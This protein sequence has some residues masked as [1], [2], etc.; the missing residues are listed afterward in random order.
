MIDILKQ[1]HP[2]RNILFFVFE[3]V[4]I[5]SS[6]LI[7]F[8]C[9]SQ[10]DGGS[11]DSFLFFRI[12]G[13][14]VI[15]QL[16][17]YYFDLYD[18]NVSN[19]VSEILI[20]LLMALGSAAIFLGLIYWFFPM[21]IVAT[22]VF[23]L[24]IV[25]LILLIL[26][27]RLLYILVLK[28][29][30]FNESI[31][32]LGSSPLALNILNH[33][34]KN[35]DC[36]YTVTAVI[37]DETH[38]IF[39]QYVANRFYFLAQK[40]KLCNVVAQFGV[41]KIVVALKDKRR[42]F[43]TEELLL[44]KVSGI[45]VLEGNTF[46]EALTGKLMVCEINPSWL[47]FSRGFYHSRLTAYSKRLGDLVISSLLLVLLFPVGVL[48]A[49]L[50]KLDS[51]GPVL[52][53]QERVGKYKKVYIMY[54]FR[55][56]INDAE[57]NTGPVWAQENDSRITRMGRFMRWCRLDELPQLWNV[58]IGNMSLVGPRPERQYFVD[59][60]EKEIPYYM[61][62][63]EVKP[64]ITGWAQILYDYGASMEDTMEKLGYDLFYIKNLSCLIDMVILMRTI[65]TVL[66]GRGAR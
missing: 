23:T 13:I 61:A 43:P 17:L 2:V 48:T 35:I 1:Y 10:N 41:R 11:L 4:I 18:L 20:R 46:Y 55:S 63:F 16:A 39:D 12:S 34:D 38:E 45:E 19:S 40:S 28:K 42:Q 22:Q 64:G 57:K 44:C 9:L 32:V 14:T 59:Q 5:F 56:M 3:G 30:W 54:K 29:G 65:K 21:T 27:W 8:V 50:I 25:L 60:L 51:R 15:C 26:M 31:V 52:F 37:P 24:A 47:I 53:S 6:I 36:G 66:F 7:S 58:F 49:V 62:R 33:I